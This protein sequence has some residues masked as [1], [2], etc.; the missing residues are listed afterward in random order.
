M[1]SLLTFLNVS[2]WALIEPSQNQGLTK[3]PLLACQWKKI[4]DVSLIAIC[5]TPIH[6]LTWFVWIRARLVDAGW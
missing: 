4:S 5:K 3:F 6:G 2:Q 1:T